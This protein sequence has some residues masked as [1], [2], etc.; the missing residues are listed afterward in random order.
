MRRGVNLISAG[1]ARGLRFPLVIVPGLHE[2]RFPAR[3][4]QDPFLL[5]AERREIGRPPQ[6]PLKSQ[7]GEE[8][9][10]LFD[11]AARSAE[12]RLVLMTSRLDEGSDRERIPSEFFL[13]A[14]AAARGK[15]VGLRDLAEGIIPGFRSVSLENPAP[16]ANQ[17]AV[18]KGEIRLRLV[19]GSSLSARAALSVLAREEPQL[20]N[21]PLSYD[22][23]RWL[24]RLPPG[25]TSQ[26]YPT[27]AAPSFTFHRPRS[28]PGC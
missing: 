2:G 5:D 3:L 28:T 10:L 23:S 19:T 16:P 26:T 24:P 14:A 7:R 8:E 18:D 15:P 11:M 27:I 21:G 20:L 1:A 6:L 17:V 22:E 25:F 12:R 9:K 13:R 4:R